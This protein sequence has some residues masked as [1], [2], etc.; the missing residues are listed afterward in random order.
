MRALH[1]KVEA[2]EL[3]LAEE[4]LSRVMTG[5]MLHTSPE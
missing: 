3:K 2:D 5:E 4:G 1:S